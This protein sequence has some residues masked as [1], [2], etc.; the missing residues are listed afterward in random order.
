MWTLYQTTINNWNT[1]KKNP[2][3][4]DAI[5]LNGIS[6]TGILHFE[7]YKNLTHESYELNS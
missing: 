5:K 1:E 4:S 6:T 7:N 2:Y 3:S